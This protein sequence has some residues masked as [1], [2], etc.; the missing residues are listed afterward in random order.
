MVSEKLPLAADGNHL[1]TQ[2]QAVCRKLRELETLNIERDISIKFI[3][4]SPPWDSVNLAE[5]EAERV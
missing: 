1:K 5:K 3:P 4:N 2:S